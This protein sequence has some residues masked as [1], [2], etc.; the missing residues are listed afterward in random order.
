MVQTTESKFNN[1]Y[2]FKD[3]STS[4]VLSF[5]NYT[6]LTDG[7]KVSGF[8]II[9]TVCLDWMQMVCYN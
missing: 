9:D 3:S 8:E 6:T 4:T 1:F 5:L 7:I 2:N